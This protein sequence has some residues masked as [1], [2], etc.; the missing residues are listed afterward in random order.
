MGL[1]ANILREPR[2]TGLA[3]ATAAVALGIFYLVDGGAPVRHLA[4]NLAAYAGVSGG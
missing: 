2:A 3:C 4:I 1:L